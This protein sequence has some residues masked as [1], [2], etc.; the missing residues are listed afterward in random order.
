[1]ETSQVGVGSVVRSAGWLTLARSWFACTAF[2]VLIALVIQVRVVLEQDSGFFDSDAERVANIFT[3]FTIWSNMLVGVTCAL[4]ALRL[5]RR[6]RAFRTIYLTG[7]LMITV[8]FVVVIVALDPITEYEGKAAA[9]D[10]LTHKLVPVM[11]VLGWL[12]FGPRR[13]VD[14]QVVLGSLV[15]PIVWLIFTLVRGPFASDF[16]PYPFVDVA[17]LGYPRVLLNCAV[18]AVLFL[19]LAMGAQALDERLPKIPRSSER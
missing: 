14:R 9:A 10:F 6:S 18:V 4:L 17:E 19:G 2:V 1:M 7:V 12:I 3:Y 5:D 15:I 13:Q 8:T 11:S 16:Y